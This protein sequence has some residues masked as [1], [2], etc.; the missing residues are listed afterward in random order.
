MA[1][2]NQEGGAAAAASPDPGAGPGCQGALPEGSEGQAD[3]TSANIDPGVVG[4]VSMRL[5]SAWLAAMF[6][7]E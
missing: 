1:A 7:V 6:G 2:G 3:E 4:Q 5:T